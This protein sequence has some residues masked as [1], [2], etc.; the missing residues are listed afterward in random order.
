[1]AASASLRLDMS[2]MPEQTVGINSLL[3]SDWDFVPGK[4]EKAQVERTIDRPKR[5][6]R[7]KKRREGGRA[8]RRGKEDPPSPPSSG[9]AP[10]D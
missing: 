7:Q 1:M 8:T 5:G 6:G 4:F 3:A 10:T 9:T 2:Q